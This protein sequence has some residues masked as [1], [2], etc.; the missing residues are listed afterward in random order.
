MPEWLLGTWRS[1]GSKSA[2]FESWTVDQNHSWKGIS[3]R[4]VEGDTVVLEQMA[5]ISRPDGLFF[6]AD[7]PH[8]EKPIEFKAITITKT[9]YVFENP[10]HDFPKRIIYY[11]S[12][13]D[14][15]R[16]R[17]EGDG[18]ILDFIFIREE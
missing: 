9:K 17:I 2:T 6:I 18:K 11:R 4:M 3:W 15:L 13:N 14:T 7:V 8:N 16:A 1:L 12:K 10:T 5:L